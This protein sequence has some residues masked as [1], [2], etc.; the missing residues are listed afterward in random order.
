MKRDLISC[1]EFA[2][3]WI[4]W[5]IDGWP[6]GVFCGVYRWWDV[7]EYFASSYRMCRILMLTRMNLRDE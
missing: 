1:Y 4:W 7:A 2:K 6:Y 5:T 3:D